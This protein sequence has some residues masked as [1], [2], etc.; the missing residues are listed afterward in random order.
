MGANKEHPATCRCPACWQKNKGLR[1][2]EA[3]E[4]KAKKADNTHLQKA[5]LCFKETFQKR[6]ETDPLDVVGAKMWILKTPKDVA[7]LAKQVEAS[8]MAAEHKLNARSSRSHCLVRLYAFRRVGDKIVQQP[9]LFVDLAG[10]E[11]VSKSNVKG[12][13]LKE[14]LGINQS[15]AT[16]GRV[17]KRLSLNEGGH[18]PFRDS[19][20]TILLRS[21]FESPKSFTQIVVNVASESVHVEETLSSLRFGSRV[22]AVRTTACIVAGQDEDKKVTDSAQQ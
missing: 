2:K 22:A 17:I 14:A 19:T 5:A 6:E 1:V 11:R 8:R 20:L 3:L 18:I 7:K 10:S 9:F 16:L 15:L 4:R 13:R 21:A 12:I